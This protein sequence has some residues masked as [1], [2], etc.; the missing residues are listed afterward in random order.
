[1]RNSPDQSPYW[2]DTFG[3]ERYFVVCSNDNVA[4]MIFSAP[5]CGT[6][7]GTDT[8]QLGICKRKYLLQMFLC[9][10]VW[11]SHVTRVCGL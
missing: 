7:C 2:G 5:A 8:S 6:S 4:N 10:G 11:F 3:E 1:V 9:H